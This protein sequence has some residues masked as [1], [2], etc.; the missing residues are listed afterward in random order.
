MKEAEKKV[1]PFSF[2]FFSNFLGFVSIMSVYLDVPCHTMSMHV[3]VLFGF[4]YVD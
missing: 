3:D 4:V 2:H 1:L